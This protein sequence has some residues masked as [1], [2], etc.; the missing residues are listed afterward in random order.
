V[1]SGLE[2]HNHSIENVR[3]KEFDI[4]DYWKVSSNKYPV[5]SLLAK[6]VP[7]VPASTVPSE[8]HR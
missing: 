8:S 5:L 6:D 2:E 3:T 1:K 4:L 7:A